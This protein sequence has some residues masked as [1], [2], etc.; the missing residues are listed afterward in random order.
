MGDMSSFL[1][2]NPSAIEGAARIFDFGNNLFV[3]N[4]S[5][6]EIEADEIALTMDYHAICRDL[7]SAN[8]EHESGQGKQKP[9]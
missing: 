2:A 6:T 8:E 7:N 3:Y 5:P 9:Q 4:S 1:F